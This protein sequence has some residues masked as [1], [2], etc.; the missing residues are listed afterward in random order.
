MTLKTYD[1]YVS[2]RAAGFGAI[3]PFYGDLQTA[4]TG[5]LF[6]GQAG[7]I[8]TVGTIEAM[9]S[10]PSG[11]TAFIATAIDCLSTAGAAPLWIAKAT[12]L[13]NLNIATPTFSAGSTMPTS[14]QGNTASSQTYSTVIGEV[15]TVL[16]A[17][18]GNFT[19]TYNANDTTTG[20]TT[21]SAALTAS[22]AV[23]T[24]GFITL[25]GAHWGASQITAATRT[26]GTTP[27]GVITFW[28]LQSI[29]MISQGYNGTL[30]AFRNM[31][32]ATLNPFRL[33]AGDQ[34][35]FFSLGSLVTRGLIGSIHFIGDS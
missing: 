2:R 22:A 24:C 11:V 5:T 34:I 1:D 29:C 21:T 27:T 6:T 8:T 13:G 33:G 9:P 31:L 20:N 17:T 3:K 15:T 19:I 12:N 26:A 10:L 32:S 7:S 14:T 18:P 28:G 30:P 16:N 35:K 23:H 25:N 4:G